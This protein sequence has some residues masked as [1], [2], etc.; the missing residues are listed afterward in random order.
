VDGAGGATVTAATQEAIVTVRRQWNDW[1]TGTVAADKLRDFHW[2]SS[3]GGVGAASPR[4]MLYA[5]MFCDSLLS[6]EI[7]HSCA[8]GPGPHDILVCIVKKDNPKIFDDLAK[9]VRT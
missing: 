5:R 9:G 6:G 4:P 1:K 7:G 2:R 3:S 8:H